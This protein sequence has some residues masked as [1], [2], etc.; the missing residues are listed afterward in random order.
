MDQFPSLIRSLCSSFWIFWPVILVVLNEQPGSSLWE[1]DSLWVSALLSR[2][3]FGEKPVVR[4]E[5]TTSSTMV[6]ETAARLDAQRRPAHNKHIYNHTISLVSPQLCHTCTHAAR[7][8]RN[9]ALTL[10]LARRRVKREK[11]A[12]RA[13]QVT[14][15]QRQ[16]SAALS[17]SPRRVYGATTPSVTVAPSQSMRQQWIIFIQH[18]CSMIHWTCWRYFNNES[19]HNELLM[20]NL[21]M[22]LI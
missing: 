1:E 20:K 15:E 13:G 10:T 5:H 19:L 14:G 3:R 6:V 9:T 7:F 17:Q 11:G 21:E 16:I 22:K 4:C 2:W 18:R 12:Q 8:L